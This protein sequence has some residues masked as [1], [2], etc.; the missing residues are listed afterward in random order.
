MYRVLYFPANARK[1][2]FRWV[3]KMNKPDPL[4]HTPIDISNMIK[5]DRVIVCHIPG[6]ALDCTS[7]ERPVTIYYDKFH[8]AYPLNKSVVEST[9]GLNGCHWGGP[10]VAAAGEDGEAD[11]DLA[12]F[13]RLV[14]WWIRLFDIGTRVTCC[15]KMVHAVMLPCDGEQRLKGITASQAVK[16]PVSGLLFKDD[17]SISEISKVRRSS[18]IHTKSNHVAAHWHATPCRRI[19]HQVESLDRA[20]R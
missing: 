10:I 5:A 4:K 20:W 12:D 1:P 7:P 13:Q 19:R 9:Q 17:S 15:S 3:P 14:A 8:E 18:S 6:N 11:F 2:E 16:F